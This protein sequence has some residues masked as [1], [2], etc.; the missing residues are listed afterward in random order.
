MG[1]F[2]NLTEN[3]NKFKNLIIDII[4]TIL[5]ATV[6]AFGIS[7]FLLPNQLSSGGFSGIATIIYYL[8]NLPM[9]ATILA[10]NIPLFLFSGYKIGKNF[11]IKSLV[12]TISLSVSIDFFD[13]FEPLTEDKFLACIYGGI[14]IGIGT[15]II[16]KVNSSTGGTDMVSNILRK[17]NPRISMGNVIVIIDTIIVIFN[18]IFFKRIDIG[19]Y[20][21]IAIYL[22][23]KM[24]DIIFEGIYFTK[25]L[26]IVSSKTEKIAEVIEQELKRGVTGL[27]GKGMYTKK[28]RLVLLCAAQRN[29]VARVKQM[30]KKIDP[31][32]FIII[33][34]ARE[35]LGEGFKRE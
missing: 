7:F 6:M 8:F 33:S 19:L 29:D 27:Y 31:D 21:A 18:V 13:K 15:A 10:L 1:D 32:C 14:I 34:N 3:E 2:M 25:M 30:A 9:G 35:V 23:G 20:S 28:D 22:I 16:L 17:F 11:F 24:I 26:I 12:G 4:G 5:G